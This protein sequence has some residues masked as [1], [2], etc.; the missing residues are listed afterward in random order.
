[1][2]RDPCALHDPEPA[3]QGLCAEKR[4]AIADPE[5]AR[6]ALVGRALVAVADHGEGPV[7]IPEFR[8]REKQALEVRVAV[9]PA[10]VHDVRGLLYVGRTDRAH[11]DPVGDDL[12]GLGRSPEFEHVRLDQL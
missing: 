10:G 5:V 11:V 7:Q 1:V 9:E 12:R 3:L 6:L 8:E 4:D 2:D